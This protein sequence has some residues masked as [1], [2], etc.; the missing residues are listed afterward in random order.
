MLEPIIERANETLKINPGDYRGEDDLLYCGICRT[1]KECYITPPGVE[2]T[3]AVPALCKC[4]QEKAAAAEEEKRR[5]RYRKDCFAFPDQYNATF[6]KD[7]GH[8][9]DKTK[10]GIAY[11]ERFDTAKLEG[12]GYVFYSAC[13]MGKSHSAYQIANAL[14]DRLYRVKM[15]QFDELFNAA[16]MERDKNAFFR[17]LSQYDL[18]ILDDLGAEKKSDTMRSFVFTVIDTLYRSRTPF[19]ITTNLTFEEITN[20]TDREMVR[21]Y[22]RILE[23]CDLICFDRPEGSIRAQK[24]KER[25][26]RKT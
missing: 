19:I 5:E 21:I 22:E 15:W 24:K 7:E 14:V 26:D 25:R 17:T 11:V 6:A 9:P 2:K 16:Q 1:P 13:G 18:V 12:E 8:N 23:R 4:E 20:P 10:L 3:T